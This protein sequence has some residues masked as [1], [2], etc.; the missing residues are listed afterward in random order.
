MAHWI[1]PA[2]TTLGVAELLAS[3]KQTV[4]AYS[5][6]SVL[7]LVARLHPGERWWVDGNVGG[8]VGRGKY[9]SK[10]AGTKGSL[11]CC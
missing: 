5:S 6:A 9:P 2:L 4:F 7:F 10:Q 3:N 1:L 11:W 8:W